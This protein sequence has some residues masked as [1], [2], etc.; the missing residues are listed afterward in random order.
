MYILANLWFTKLIKQFFFWIDKIVYNFISLIYDLMITIAR[1]SV[2][3]QSDIVDMAEKIYQLLTVFMIFKVTLSL[4]T[5]VVN[6]D[7]FSDKTKGISKLG[8]NIVISLALLILTPYIFNYAYELQT[9]ILEDNSLA[10]LI[11]GGSAEEENSFFNTAGDDMAYI[12]MSAFFTPNVSIG[13]LQDCTT[14]LTKQNIDGQEKYLFNEDCSGMDD[15]YTSLNDGNSLYALIGDDFSETTL[16]NYVA[17]VNNNSLGLMFRQDLVLATDSNDN[18]IM[19]YKFIFSTVVGCIIILLLLTF[20]MDVALR[21]IK[22]AFLQLIAPIPI[23]SYVDPK[24]G[25]DGLFKK[26]YELCF[27]TYTSLFIRLIALYFAVYIISRVADM[28]MVD[29]IDGSY[30]TNKLVAIFIIVG[31]LMFAKQLPKILEG[32]GIKLDGDGKFFLNPLKKFEEQSFGGKNIT[33]MARGAMTGTMGALSGAGFGRAFSGAWRGLTSGKGWKETGKAEAEMNKKM[34]QARLDGS[35]FRGRMGAKFSELTGLMS[36]SE[37][38]AR[39]KHDIETRQRHFDEQAKS[40]ED[41]IKPTKTQISREKS[42][43][44]SVKAMEDRAI[45]EIEQ[46]NSWVGSEYKVRKKNEEFVENNIGKEIDRRWE[47]RDIDYAQYRIRKAQKEQQAAIQHNDQ[48]A[49]ARAQASEA[50]ARQ[51]LDEAQ[52]NLGQTT[53]VT[54]TT[55]DAAWASSMASDWLKDE[56]MKTYMT[57]ASSGVIDDA[58]FRNMRATAEQAAE[59]VGQVLS[60]NGGDMHRQLGESKGRSGELQRGIHAQEREIERIND[61]KARLGDELRDIQ[62]RERR[63]KAD[64]SAIK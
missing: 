29:I 42:F 39:Q 64:E 51:R 7:D 25:K 52:R 16:K 2:L 60:Q 58:S 3:T 5:Y 12:T 45:G 27:K 38:I 1:T 23:L 22:L 21:S 34:R 31:A 46:G 53:R 62:E 26:W 4:I 57:D 14:L 55:E 56:G 50:A 59:T 20:C 33:G 24:S 15:N 40:I 6:P 37:E 44:D 30:Q 43:A 41:S 17:G 8:T 10:T 13:E 11:L 63:V 48:A 18:F 49:L 9:I 32:L 35:T 61:E 36:S 54:V 47:Q 19:E 28:K